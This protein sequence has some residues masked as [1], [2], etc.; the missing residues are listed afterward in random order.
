MIADQNDATV[1]RTTAVTGDS[2]LVTE[3]TLAD[4]TVEEAGSETV[5]ADLDLT[6]GGVL[7]NAELASSDPFIFTIDED[8]VI[9]VIQDG[10]ANV[11]IT[12]NEEEFTFPVEVGLDARIAT[13]TEALAPVELTTSDDTTRVVNVVITDQY[14]DDVL[15]AADTTNVVATSGDT[16]IVTVAPAADGDATDNEVPYTLTAV[17][18][19]TATITFE[20]T[21][22][23]AQEIGTVDITVAE[24]GETIA[25]YDI[26]LVDSNADYNLD[27]YT[28]DVTDNTVDVEFV[29]KDDSGIVKTVFDDTATTGLI[30]NTDDTNINENRFEIYTSDD[31]IATASITG[32]AITITAVAEGTADITIKEGNI[33]RDSITV[34][35]ADT[36]PVLTSFGLA[37][38]V[39]EIELGDADSPFSWTDIESN[40][41]A[42]DQNN[43]DFSVVAADV[44]FFTTDETVFTGGDNT[45]TLTGSVDDTATLTAKY[46][47]EV[48]TVPVVITDTT[49]P[50]ASNAADAVNGPD[51]NDSSFDADEALYFDGTAIAADGTT[52]ISGTIAAAVTDDN[53]LV[54]NITFDGTTFTVNY[55][56]GADTNTISIDLTQFT[57]EAGNAMTGSFDITNAVGTWSS[58]IN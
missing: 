47:G 17:A 21:A 12:W 40:F 46:E 29:G 7:V 15:D 11:V 55:T 16:A 48:V 26:R 41:V 50:T 18:K 2:I 5:V 22:A 13:T 39:T 35:V 20:N 54:N 6:A 10:T 14:G 53:S 4:G 37:D 45:I 34:T 43:E 31:T 23:T 42:K 52:D 49:A 1:E 3:A 57:D 56:D 38:G 8:G 44:D 51:D 9:T 19:G 36:T 33:T 30:V 24:P 28:G 58:A 25:S 32:S 27:V